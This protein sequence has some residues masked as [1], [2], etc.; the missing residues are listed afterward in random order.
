MLAESMSLI[1]DN[2]FTRLNAGTRIND[3]PKLVILE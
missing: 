2:V 3:G 1:T